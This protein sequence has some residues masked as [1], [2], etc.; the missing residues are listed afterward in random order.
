MLQTERS[1]PRFPPTHDATFKNEV[2]KA[3]K[4]SGD[5]DVWSTDGARRTQGMKRC[6]K[7]RKKPRDA[8]KCV[9]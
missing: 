8:C 4:E 2:G 5:G 1:L 7:A 6:S 9:T 3:D